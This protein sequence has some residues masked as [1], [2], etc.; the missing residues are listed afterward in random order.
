MH[1]WMYKNDEP[2]EKIRSSKQKRC[3]TNNI[4]EKKHKRV[5]FDTNNFRCLQCGAFVSADREQSGVN[6]RNHCPH[7]LYSRHVDLLKPGDRRCKCKSRMEPVGLTIKQNLKKYGNE[8]QGEL[9]L[10]HRCCGCGIFSINRIAADDNT[11]M[12]YD[13]FLESEKNTELK[14]RLEAKRIFMLEPHDLTTV[15]AQLFGNQSLLNEFVERE[16]LANFQKCLVKDQI[17]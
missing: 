1:R 13:L 15:H 9:M 7:C 6:N 8:K 16:S 4:H 3:S 5:M 10:I 14:D 12:I 17:I 11:L 2:F